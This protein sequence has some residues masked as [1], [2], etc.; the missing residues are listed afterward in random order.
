M[1]QRILEKGKAK[2][3]L[4][5]LDELD[6]NG[7]YQQ[8]VTR[9]SERREIEMN[10]LNTLRTKYEVNFL[11]CPFITYLLAPKGQLSTIGTKLVLVIIL[12]N[13]LKRNGVIMIIIRH[14]FFCFLEVKNGN[15]SPQRPTYLV[16]IAGSF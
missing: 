10:L 8:Y 9:L 11:S 13:H 5:E 12:K 1:S 15:R 4:P 16:E 14:Y 2:Q 6:I 3:E 7:L